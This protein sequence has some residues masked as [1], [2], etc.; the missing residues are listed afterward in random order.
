MDVRMRME[1]LTPGVQHAEETDLCTEISGITSDL[2]KG[3][4]TGTEEQAVKD[5]LV[6]QRQ[7]SQAMGRV[8]TRCR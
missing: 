2:E 7:G 4:G 5:F 8:K 6:L 3:C 1:L